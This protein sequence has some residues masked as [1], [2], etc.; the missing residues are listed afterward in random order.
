MMRMDTDV[1]LIEL[2]DE[3]LQLIDEPSNSSGHL[4]KYP[5]AKDL[6]PGSWSSVHGLWLNGEAIAVFSNSGGPTTVTANSAVYLDGLLY[7]A[8]GKSVACVRPRPF[9]YK[10]SLQVDQG[11]CWGIHFD[12]THQALISHGELEI[13][14]FSTSGML[15]WSCA[16]EDIFTEVSL[17]PQFIEAIDWNGKGY[18][19]TYDGGRSVG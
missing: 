9:E 16:G 1:G 13:A 4:K 3:P 5:F 12:R 18:R 8:V 19:F 10:W 11:S 15:L 17:L 6:A 7:L 2:V 14:R